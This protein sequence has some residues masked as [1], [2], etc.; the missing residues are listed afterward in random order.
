M[1]RREMLE[2]VHS[3]RTKHAGAILDIANVNERLAGV[4]VTFAETIALIKADVRRRLALEGRRINLTNAIEVAF[5]P[6]VVAV[7]AYRIITFLHLT[8]HGVLARILDDLQQLYTG[9]EIH[10]GSI[11]GPGLV[12]GDRAGGGISEHVT[13]G[14]NC[15]VLGG[16]TMTLNANGID[17]SKGRIV[18]GDHCIIGLRARI[19]GAVT[20]GDCSQIKANAVVLQS[21][22]EPGGIL[23]GIPARRKAVAPPEAVARWNPLRSVFLLDPSGE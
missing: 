22:P 13:M 5:K 7:V 23:D 19:I 6:G 18:I 8:K 14:K 17:L 9:T 20:L 4:N 15:T 10:A 11:I 12:L 1:G 16:S 3:A 21:S 2:G